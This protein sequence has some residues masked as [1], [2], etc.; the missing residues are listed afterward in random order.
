LEHCYLLSDQ[1]TVQGENRNHIPRSAVAGARLP[2]GMDSSDEPAPEPTPD[3][4]LYHVLAGG[5]CLLISAGFGEGKSWMLEDFAL[6]M[7]RD[8]AGPVPIFIRLRDAR[9]IIK[10]R[11]ARGIG[12]NDLPTL[13]RVFMESTGLP[14]LDDNDIKELSKA[15]P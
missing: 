5:G 13:A 6:R 11:R 8:K 9:E 3:A 15:K 14:E 12:N 4:I 10:P 7:L 2:G 1:G